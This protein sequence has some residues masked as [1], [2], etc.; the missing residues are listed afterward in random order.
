M[1][2]AEFEFYFLF[3]T[4]KKS[5]NAERTQIRSRVNKSRI[6]VMLHG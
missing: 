5:I 4:E 2:N 3:P 6:M 1:L